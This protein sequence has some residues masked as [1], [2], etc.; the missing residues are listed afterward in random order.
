MFLSQYFECCLCARNL[1]TYSIFVLGFPGGSD[2][3]EPT[4]NA[5]DLGSIPGSGRSL[6]EGNGYP[7]QYSGPE[8]S[9]DRGAWRPTVHGVAKSQTRLS[10]FLHILHSTTSRHQ[11]SGFSPHWPIPWPQL[12]VL[13]CN[14]LLTLICPEVSVR[15]CRLRTQSHGATLA[16]DGCYK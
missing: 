9:M 14:S 5:G 16:S 2:G 13:Q 12:G 3:K 7:L 4:C 15:S 10:K 6:G 11:M 1:A 8:N